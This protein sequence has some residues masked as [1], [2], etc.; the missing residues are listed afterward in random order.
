M[1]GERLKEERKQSQLHVI[2]LIFNSLTKSDRTET[3]LL[4]I[5]NKIK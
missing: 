4:R 2:E 3:E 1:Y 5:L